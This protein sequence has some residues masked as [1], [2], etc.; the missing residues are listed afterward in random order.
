M[1]WYTVENESGETYDFSRNRDEAV[2]ASHEI[3]GGRVVEEPESDYDGG[4][5]GGGGC[6]GLFIAIS[7][8]IAAGSTAIVCGLLAL[9][10]RLY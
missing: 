2:K 3:S 4:G 6:L 9:V 7:A 1:P 5:G 10:S 8:T